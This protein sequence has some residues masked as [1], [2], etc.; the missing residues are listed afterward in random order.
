MDKLEF[1]V[2]TY[3]QGKLEFYN[4]FNHSG[5]RWALSMYRTGKFDEMY[6]DPK[7]KEERWCLFVFG[8]F[9]SRSEYEMIIKEWVG[10]E[11]KKV[12]VFELCIKPNEKLLRQMID[13]VDEKECKKFL[14]EWYKRQKQYGKYGY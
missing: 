14:R 13:T 6:P 5:V 3:R 1:Y 11:R 4:I 2:P 7:Q 12:D 10:D 8:D 9:W